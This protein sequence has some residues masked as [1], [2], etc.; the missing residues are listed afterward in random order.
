MTKNI[1]NVK[2]FKMRQNQ[3][4]KIPSAHLKMPN[5]MQK[6]QE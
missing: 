2:L 3:P 5:I 1:Q 4:N 6:K